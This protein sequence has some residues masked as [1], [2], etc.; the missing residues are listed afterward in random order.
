MPRCDVQRDVV[1]D[2]AGL[3]IGGV[4]AAELDQ[5][6]DHA[7]LVLNVL[8]R[9]D[10]RIGRLEAD[11]PADFDLLAQRAGQALDEIVDGLAV[12]GATAEIR[13]ALLD[14]DFGE[15]RDR[16]LEHVAL[17]DEVG[18]AVQLDERADTAFDQHV[19]SSLVGVTAGALGR[20]RD[21][22]LPEPVLGALDVALGL[23]Q[24]FLAIH[25]P[26]AR[27]LAE[28]RDILRGYVCHLFQSLLVSGVLVS[29]VLVSGVPVGRVGAVSGG[30]FDRR[31]RGRVGGGRLCFRS[32]GLGA[33]RLLGALLDLTLFRGRGVLGRTLPGLELLL[34]LGRARRARGRWPR[35]PVPPLRNA[36]PDGRCDAC[37]SRDPL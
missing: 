35:R 18:L 37:A 17:G 3:G 8:V 27:D 23:D 4:Y 9:V 19:D 1:R 24:R 16:L 25:H 12:D 2:L 28:R 5:H 20:A 32:C 22:L 7:A 15:G 30:R 6:A 33:L 13:F 26:G 36:C 34:L 11:H 29:V 31:V 14:H 10:D 21:A